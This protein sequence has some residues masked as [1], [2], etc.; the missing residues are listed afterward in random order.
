MK[1]GVSMMGPKGILRSKTEYPF[2]GMLAVMMILYM[3]PF[4][5][6]WLS[7]PAF[8]LCVY[9]IIRYDA[10]V[11]AVDYAILLAVSPLFRLPGGMS[12]FLF[13][14]LFGGIWCVIRN[15]IAGDSTLV[16]L[17]LLLCYML[18]RIQKE[19][20]GFVLCFGQLFFLVAVL[21]KMD[22]A[23]AERAAKSFCL[24]M[25]VTSLYALIFRDTSQLYLVRGAESPVFW[26]G[27][28]MRFQGVFPDPNYYMSLLLV[29]LALL[30]KLKYCGRIGTW[31]FVVQGI[32]LSAFGMLTYGKTFFLIYMLLGVTAL[33][34]LGGGKK[35]LRMILLLCLAVA[36]VGILLFADF[37]P[38]AV[39]MERFSQ[40]TTID[41]FTTGRTELIVAYWNEIR[42]DIPSLLF[43]KGLAAARLNKDPHNIY[44][45]IWYYFGL[46]G[47]VLFAVLF[48]ALV[49]SLGSRIEGFRR[50]NFI[51]CFLVI[52]VV[53]VTYFSLQGVRQILSYGSFFLA[54]LSIYFTKL[55]QANKT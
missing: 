15:G 10:K 29:G 13:L 36:A 20:G 12:L 1:A 43:G 45:E 4:V 53:M 26:G 27:T 18:T 21:P 8:G 6:M 35:P 55:E 51:S 39:V 3:A 46:I 41:D 7:V 23:T 54:F 31:S 48:V 40:A 33:F 37:S 16:A 25:M 14:I 19:F 2:T 34:L 11:F 49:Y 42:E 17:V 28:L 32:V 22:G 30:V 24:S 52:F 9:R 50:Q 44:L 5:S 47:L 38:F